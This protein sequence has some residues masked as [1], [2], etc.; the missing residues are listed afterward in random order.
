MSM[1]S[2]EA[3]RGSS[4]TGV[5]GRCAS[6]VVSKLFTAI[7]PLTTGP[8]VRY[9]KLPAARGIIRFTPYLSIGVCAGALWPMPA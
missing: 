1:T 4:Y 8:A 3:V 7:V 6:C 2:S 9:C 5:I